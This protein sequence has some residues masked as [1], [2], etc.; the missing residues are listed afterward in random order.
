MEDLKSTVALMESDDYQERLIAEYWQTKI[1]Y[2][3][4]KKYNNTIEAHNGT[5]VEPPHTCSLEFLRTQE[6]AMARYLSILEKR[7]AIEQIPI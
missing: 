2:E 4:L 1:R 7:I 6:K 3:R 5:E